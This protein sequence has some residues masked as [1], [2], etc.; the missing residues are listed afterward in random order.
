MTP[1]S[2][3]NVQLDTLCGILDRGSAELSAVFE[4]IFGQPAEQLIV[5]PQM[6]PIVE[7]GRKFASQ[8]LV[9]VHAN[10]SGDLEGAFLLLQKELDFPGM[11]NAIEA[12]VSAGNNAPD[13]TDFLVR[14]WA[15]QSLYDDAEKAGVSDADLKDT[16]GELGNVILG[17]YLSAIY[18]QVGLATFQDLPEANIQDRER[19]ELRAAIEAYGQEAGSAF[20]SEISCTIGGEKTRMWLVLF[21]RH[22]GYQKLLERL[23]SA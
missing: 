10:F 23:N 1:N 21:L 11:R 6:C 5:A 22:D 20:L 9:T 14:D 8:E 18:A 19:A 15:N 7:L 4:M 2:L 3:N 13:P 12:A 16:L 17:S